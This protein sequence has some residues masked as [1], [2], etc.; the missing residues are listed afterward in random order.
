MSTTEGKPSVPAS[1]SALLLIIWTNVFI[2]IITY[3]L[4]DKQAVDFSYSYDPSSSNHHWVYMLL[5]M[6]AHGS[7]GHLFNNM[8]A[9]SL[10]GKAL[11]EPPQGQALPVAVFIII[12]LGSGL[13]GEALQESAFRH[14]QVTSQNRVDAMVTRLT[15]TYTCDPGSWYCLRSFNAGVENISRWYS[16]GYYA[17]DTLAVTVSSSSKSLGASGAVYGVIGAR[18]Y[19]IIFRSDVYRVNRCIRSTTTAKNFISSLGG[20][21]VY[22]YV[23]KCSIMVLA[24]SMYDA[25]EVSVDYTIYLLEWLLYFIIIVHPICSD[26]MLTVGEDLEDFTNRFYQRDNVG[27]YAHVGGFAFGLVLAFLYDKAVLDAPVTVEAAKKLLGTK[28]IK[29]IMTLGS[30][31]AVDFTGC[32]TKDDLIDVAAKAQSIRNELRQH[33]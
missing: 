11:I 10:E 26:I 32:V 16:N 24:S 22:E 25:L 13:V 33:P 20:K 30:N 1:R 6:F 18:L 15:S 9:L 19:L 5:S 17:K 7:V 2:H 8:L 29:D 31:H 4:G 28:S 3:A 27:R 21:A 23:S 14:F 12:Y